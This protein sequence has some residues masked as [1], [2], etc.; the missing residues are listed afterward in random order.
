[1]TRSTRD[2]GEIRPKSSTRVKPSP[3]TANVK[4]EGIVVRSYERFLAL[5]VALGLAVMWVARVTLLGLCVLTD[6]LP[7]RVCCGG[8]LLD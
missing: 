6:A 4:Q 3:A 5:P 2:A 1:M 8:L 7:F